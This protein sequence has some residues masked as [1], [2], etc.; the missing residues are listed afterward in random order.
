VP[1]HPLDAYLLD[2]HPA[3]AATI[4]AV[5]ADRSQIE[6]AQPF[7]RALEAL[8]ARV[9]DEALIALRLALAGRIPDDA[10][11]VTLRA[12]VAAARRGDAAARA[13]YLA[14]VETA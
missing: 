4:E 3:K 13:A 2:G 7:Y 1:L 12:H 10:A 11:I 5:L 9:A 8:G 14:A 6:R